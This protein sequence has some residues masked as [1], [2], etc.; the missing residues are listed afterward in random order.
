LN[1]VQRG[2]QGG[3]AGPRP[4]LSEAVVEDLAAEIIGGELPPG[5]TLPTEPQLCARFGVSRTVIRDAMAQ[6]ARSGLVNVR[7]GVGTV[8][9]DREQWHELDPMLLR[10]RAARGLIGDLVPDLLAIRRLVEIEVAGQAACRR[11]EQDLATMAELLERMDA[12]LDQPALYNDADIAFHNALLAATG[13]D[14]LLQLMRPVNELR[15][16]GSV[17]TSS[18]AHDIVLASVA[19]HHAIFDAVRVQDVNAARTA[20]ERHVTEFERDLL[21]AVGR[22]TDTAAG[23][24]R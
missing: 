7:Q 13:N 4:R 6:L 5:G 21:S 17:I 9:L 2:R 14:L 8:V 3:R 16:I 24:G 1:V 19:G 23:A 18:R 11:T 20:M 15:R 10:I 12:H 22:A